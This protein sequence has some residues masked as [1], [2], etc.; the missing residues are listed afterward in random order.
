VDRTKSSTSSDAR[1]ASSP[2]RRV[3]ED[4]RHR[5][6]KGLDRNGG[7]PLHAL[8]DAKLAVPSLRRGVVDRA[9]ILPALDRGDDA[10]LTLV[11]AP[12]GYG[13]TTAVR[14]WCARRGVALAWVTLDDGDND[15]VSLWRY[16]AMAVDRVR[17]GLGRGALRRL[18]V[19]G[20]PVE[21][22]IDELMNGV[23]ALGSELVVVLDDLD[24]VV[25][26]ESLVRCF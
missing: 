13:K 7:G 4:S 12:A 9:R 10:A 11:A 22:A 6:E 1:S 24:A 26:E 20:A 18:G 8:V 19:A 16:V 17:S 23:G 21:V 2:S 5:A 14:A 3:A 15:P 25:S